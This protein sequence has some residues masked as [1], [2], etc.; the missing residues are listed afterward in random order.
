LFKR[1]Y[2]HQCS[3]MSLC[4]LPGE[5]LE[6][7]AK[8]ARPPDV[9]QLCLAMKGPHASS[10]VPLLTRLMNASLIESMKLSLRE[11]NASF[12]DDIDLFNSF[13][14]LALSLK[15]NSVAMSG[16]VVVQA[17][18]GETWGGSDIDVYCTHDAAPVVRSWL[19]ADV[20]QVLVGIDS[21]YSQGQHRAAL[22]GMRTQRF[23][24]DG[25]PIFQVEHWANAP[26]DGEL[27]RSDEDG[28]VDRQWQ[29]N[30]KEVYRP[31]PVFFRDGVVLDGPAE[32]TD[33]ASRLREVRSWKDVLSIPHE[34]RLCSRAGRD[35]RKDFINIDLIVMHPESRIVDA[36]DDFDIEI[37]KCTWDGHKFRIPSPRNTFE[38]RTEL[39]S[40]PE[41][42]DMLQYAAGIA[43]QSKKSFQAMLREMLD[44]E[45]VLDDEGDEQAQTLP[46]E[47]QSFER[48]LLL[49]EVKSIERE[50]KNT[51]R[52]NGWSSS[53]EL[54]VD[55]LGIFS[56]SLDDNLPLGVLSLVKQ[57]R[58]MSIENVL[59]RQSAEEEDD[60]ESRLVGDDALYAT[61]NSN[62]KWYNRLLKYKRRGIDITPFP[63][64]SAAM[65]TLPTSF[66]QLE[67]DD[68]EAG[69]PENY[70]WW[71]RDEFEVR[72]TDLL[73]A[74]IDREQEERFAANEMKRRSAYFA[75]LRQV[76]NCLGGTVDAQW[77]SS[78]EDSFAP[79]SVPSDDDDDDDDEMVD[80]S[81]VEAC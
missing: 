28:A 67:L 15:P 41:A 10:D 40:S 1:F 17:A 70:D 9:Y 45:G 27:F 49:S 57:L 18:L 61:H 31:S 46:T 69:D 75:L 44:D 43:K 78:D 16:S 80:D 24:R 37:C 60:D 55:T 14:N 72:D 74:R 2:F 29:F 6:V 8:S 65:R 51:P 12:R 32:T 20:H 64:V 54:I 63:T 52:T 21:G 53:L 35:S 36:I 19:I 42:S 39:A 66:A 26:K 73:V 56:P 25:D 62:V 68:E 5:V 58:L 71:P 4:S 33:D 34:P 23:N 30:L 38:R 48:E 77:L 79:A 22:S 50:L 81:V 59:S 76:K 47:I 13:V 7:V 11:N 3:T